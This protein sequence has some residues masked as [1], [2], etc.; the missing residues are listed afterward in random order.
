[1]HLLID[2]FQVP[3]RVKVCVIDIGKREKRRKKKR[4]LRKKDRK[5]N[6]GSVWI[7]TKVV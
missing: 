3:A 4:S 1:M 7:I 5:L 6:R 2:D